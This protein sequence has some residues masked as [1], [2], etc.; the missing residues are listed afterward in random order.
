[1]HEGV[2]ACTPYFSLTTLRLAADAV[3][4]SA[5]P[6]AW[7]TTNSLCI[8]HTALRHTCVKL[9]GPSRSSTSP[10][11]RSK[12]SARVCRASATSFDVSSPPNAR[13]RLVYRP[14]VDAGKSCANQCH[15]PRVIRRIWQP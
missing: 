2:Q 15:Q 12:R 13:S 3:S 8:L 9:R 4:A 10:K 7:Q 6:H 1:M 14:G 11:T 5:S